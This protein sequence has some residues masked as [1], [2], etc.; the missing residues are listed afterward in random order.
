MTLGPAPAPVGA[1]KAVPTS[2]KVDWQRIRTLILPFLWPRGSVELR[3]R[4]VAALA[5]LV[6]AKLITVD[7]KS[8]V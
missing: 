2:Q 8:V 4:V 5:L 6:L 7:R 1:P 3:V